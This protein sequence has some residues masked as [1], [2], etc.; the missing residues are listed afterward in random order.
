MPAPVDIDEGRI[1]GGPHRF[2]TG[3]FEPEAAAA[4]GELAGAA[5]RHR[6]AGQLHA[7]HGQTH[8]A[9]ECV[10]SLVVCRGPGTLS[11]TAAGRV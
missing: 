7:G 1:H 8:A 11:P 2:R 6:L 5:H 4:D 10:T 3:I 9:D